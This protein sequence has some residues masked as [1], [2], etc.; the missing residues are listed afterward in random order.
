M[1]TGFLAAV[2]RP[3]YTGANRCWPC[4]IANG[5]LVVLGA[6]FAGQLWP[7]A[8]VAVLVAGAASILLRGYAIPYTPRLAPRVV[9]LLPFEVH[10][11]RRSESLPPDEDDGEAVLLALLDAD[12]LVEDGDL[13]LDPAFEDAWNDEMAALRER[14]DEALAA[15]VADAVPGDVDAR[16]ELDGV[17]VESGG[18]SAWLER[19][20]AIADAAAVR[21]LAAFD[22]PERYRTAAAAALRLFLRTCPVCGGPVSRAT[23]RN[24]CGGTSAYGT[25]EREVLA[26]ESCDAVV[27]E[28]DE[29]AG[30]RSRPKAGS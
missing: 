23:R 8:A 24:C 6:F 12:A 17:R 5:G 27:H 25:P 14:D 3:E 9:G 7:P 29:D 30:E 10:P 21:T 18:G 22:V 26:C 4:T 16:P 15:A 2:R 11:D 20:A 28:F 13:D 19:P 1:S